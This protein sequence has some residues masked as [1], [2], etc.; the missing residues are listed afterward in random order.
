M[1]KRSTGEARTIFDEIDTVW[2]AGL[3]RLTHGVSPA[4]LGSAFYAWASHLAQA[5]GKTLEIAFYPALHAQD[6]VRR[7]TCEKSEACAADPRFK[8]EAWDAW[9]WRLYAE[10]FL[11]TEAW[12]EQIAVGVPGLDDHVEQVASFTVRQIMDA[13]CP[14]NFPSTNPDLFHKTLNS[15]GAN[16]VRGGWNAFQDM[17]RLASGAAADG[18]FKVGENLAVTPGEV[19]FRNDL[20][21]LI[22]YAPQTRSVYREPILIIPAWIMKFYILDLSPGNSLVRWLV[23]QGHTVFMVSWKNPGAEDSERGMD[24]YYRLGAMAAIDNVS[25]VMPKTKIHLAGYCLGGTLA[26]ITAAAMARDGD[27]RLKS[28]SLLA[29]QGDF[30][31]AGELMLFVTHSEV[32]FLTNMMKMKGYLD[33]KEMAGAFQMLR[34]YD[35]I[36]SKIVSDYFEGQ[37]RAALDLMAWN[38]DATRMP[39]RMH[40]E[41]LQKLF[42][43]ND[44]SEGRYTTEGKPVAPENIKAPVFCVG[45]EKDHVAPWRSVH[46]I[47]LMTNGEITFVLTTGGHNAGIV[48][49]PGHKGR[50]YHVRARAPDEPYLDPDQ[51][52]EKAEQRAG[53]WWPAWHDWLAQRSAKEKIVPPPLGESLCAAPG[54]YVFQK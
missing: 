26:M 10:A 6:F 50:S 31:E 23:A 30:S 40:S 4:G 44:L 5:P 34:S 7:L 54:T 52:L 41:Y 13:L 39:Y 17:Q 36:W 15:G 18:E 35:L 16:L 37:R 53:S 8:S 49:E 24:D 22:R 42:L 45:T 20:M 25:K 11:A 1:S 51:W 2:Q 3:G 32:S 33:T 9:P 28:L 43:H 38:E 29:A 27:D 46:K 47:H 14:A 21:E 48:S 19:I 12:A